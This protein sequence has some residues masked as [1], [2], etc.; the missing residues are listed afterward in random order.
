MPGKVG[1]ALWAEHLA[2]YKLAA[3][4]AA[5]RRVLDFACGTGYGTALLKQAGAKVVVG[6]DRSLEAIAYACEKFSGPGLS[7][8]S[9]DCLEPGFRAARFD[10]VVSFETIEHV[11]F[12]ERFLAEVSRLVEPGGRFVLSTPN[13]KTYTDERPWEKNRFHTRE[14]YWQEL[15]GALEAVFRRVWLY[16]QSISEGVFFTRYPNLDRS[17]PTGAERRAPILAT[18][19]G[20]NP[21]D[22]DYLVAICSPGPAAEE[23]PGFFVVTETHELHDKRRRIL[24]LQDEVTE[25]NRW[26][27]QLDRAMSRQRL[28]IEK[29][30]RKLAECPMKPP[31]AAPAASALRVPSI[32]RRRAVFIQSGS[33]EKAAECLEVLAASVFPESPLLYVIHAP[34]ALPERA[35]LPAGTE[36]LVA[37]TTFKDLFALSLLFR[38][39]PLEGCACLFFGDPGYRRFKLLSLLL[40]RRSLVVF[41][42]NGDWFFVSLRKLARHVAW[43]VR[44]RNA[45][46]GIW[47]D[48]RSGL[49]ILRAEGP[50]ALLERIRQRLR[51][52]G[53]HRHP[54]G[55]RLWL[56]RRTRSLT[57][58]VY[59]SVDLSIVIP[60]HD[61]E[62]MTSHCLR[63]ILRNARGLRYEVIVVDDGSGPAMS[64][65]LSRQRNV[66]VVRRECAEGFVAACNQGAEVAR[67]RVILFLNNDTEVQPGA[68]Q[69]FLETFELRPDCGAV[70][71]KLIYPNG[72]LQEAGG[73][74]WRDGEAWNCGRGGNP[75]APEYNYLREVDYC[76]G[77]AL[78]VRRDLFEGLGG[79][80]SAFSPG[81]WE[82]TDLCFRVRRAGFSV[83]YQP[84]A[85]VVHLEGATAGRETSRGM[86]AFQ[87]PNGERFRERWQGVLRDHLEQAP[88]LFFA[89]RDRYRD[90][91]ILVIDHYVPTPDRDAGSYVMYSLLVSL[92]RLGHRVVFWPDNLDK[93]PGYTEDLQ[94]QGIEVLYGSL[95]F[96]R[97]VEE[98][99]PFID[100]VIIHRA[101]MAQKYLALLGTSIDRRAYLCADLEHV[102]ERRRLEVLGQ[103]SVDVDSLKLREASIAA[104]VDHI[105]VHSPVEKE[106]L[107][108]EF[109]AVEVSVLP[110]PVKVWSGDGE[111]YSRRENLL[112]VGSTHPPNVDAVSFYEDALRAPL[113]A[114]LPG[115]RLTVAGEVSRNVRR[116]P[117]RPGLDLLGFVPDL[118][119]LYSSH[120][121]F[122]APL[123]YGAGIKGKILEA[124][125]FGIPVVT[126]PV[127]AEGIPLVNGS[128]AYIAETAE[129]LV[130]AIYRLYS[131]EETWTRVRNEARSIIER[132]YS[133]ESFLARVRALVQSLEDRVPENGAKPRHVESF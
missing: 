99:G 127:G 71:A 15:R 66:R 91:T 3:R 108:R 88:A 106:I 29:L 32:Q 20:D 42:E 128:S 21:D 125:S 23:L 73:V 68:L 129:D 58:P 44:E 122:V 19:E 124:M 54:V 131:C 120:R 90:K 65:M 61:G 11:S 74:V 130:E 31:P 70:G 14:F 51:A 69:A 98:A 52:R 67:G 45:A 41:N 132:E 93:T 112:F 77:A 92:A 39:L 30:E 119:D 34:E 24:E 17:L 16:G 72:A 76:S 12:Y 89:A 96:D 22:C 116:G 10:L 18:G 83:L 7:F 86:K 80:D 55:R 104:Q 78:A 49:R 84:R 85:L 9:M 117:D 64:R 43:R 105:A 87:I 115:L 75:A 94:Q 8:S 28:E 37:G 82:D 101:R 56:L 36:V 107:A 126:T 121:V 114:R 13:K 79:F 81:Y 48:L 25:R 6:V 97:F 1:A 53:G 102:R 110:L 4:F 26:A 2:R 100:M 60:V 5:G 59:E 62:R 133:G 111:P 47:R 123:R 40:W 33:P 109:P 46:N 63:S 35:A 50:A 103:A 113:E 95:R 27:R 57:F 118:S 38:L